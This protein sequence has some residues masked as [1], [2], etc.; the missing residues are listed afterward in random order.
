MGAR[1]SAGGGAAAGVG[2]A[3]G[4]VCWVAL[5]LGK[6]DLGMTEGFVGAR[7]RRMISASMAAACA[8]ECAG[9]GGAS[10]SGTFILGM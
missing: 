1:G 4:G 3:G 10:E 9:A 8:G 7:G 6:V 5:A 2:G